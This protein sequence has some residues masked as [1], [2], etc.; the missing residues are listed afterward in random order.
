[1]HN[2]RWR[3][4]VRVA[5]PNPV[6]ASLLLEQFGGPDGELSAAMRYFLQGLGE[7]A[8]G[9]KDLLR[10]IATKE[11]SHLEEIGRIVA[12]LN[13]GAKSQLA[14]GAMEEAELYLSPTRR[15]ASSSRWL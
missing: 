15:G 2:K 4:S 7:E 11:L 6:L 10:D 3:S 5:E 1:M 13:K 12:M 8:P 14:E 9:G